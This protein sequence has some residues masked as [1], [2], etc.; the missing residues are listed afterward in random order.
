MAPRPPSFDERNV[1]DKPPWIRSLPPF[2]AARISEIDLRHERRVESLQA[3]DELVEA[4]VNDLRGHGAL[5]NT[6]V[7]F[8]SD[9]GW[10]HGE[11]R[12]P[13]EKHQP[14]E[15]SVRVPLL[16]RGPG[17]AAGS[18]TGKLTLNT[19]FFPTFTDLAGAPTPE[20]IDGRSLRPLLEDRVT[21]WRSAI[22]VEQRRVDP[23][24]RETARHVLR[25]AHGPEGSTSSTQTAPKSSTTSGATLTNG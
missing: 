8:T 22:L 15:E 7:V 3:V 9:N 19:D 16:V 23:D 21:T 2:T 20:Y 1:I 25:R 4:L 12:I 11:H 13:A 5:G 6:Y 17:V 24:L 10:H 18:A 14:Y